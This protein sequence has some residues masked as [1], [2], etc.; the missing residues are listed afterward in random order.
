MI[1]YYNKPVEG[2]KSQ[3]AFEYVEKI[4]ALDSSWKDL[5]P[6]DRKAHRLAELKPV[7]DEYWKFLNSFEADKIPIL[8]RHRLIR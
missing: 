6:D 7:M 3:K 4:F 5:P 1:D 2:S 8:A